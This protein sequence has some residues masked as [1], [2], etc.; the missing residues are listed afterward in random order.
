[1][2]IRA[3]EEHRTARSLVPFGLSG[4]SLTELIGVLALIAIVVALMLP[5]LRNPIQRAQMSKGATDEAKIADAAMACDTI[6]AALSDHSARYGSLAVDGTATPP[7]PLRLAPAFAHY[8]GLL[9]REQ[10]IDKPFA[11][12]IGDGSS[13]TQVQAVS[14]AG[15]GF[16]VGARV[17]ATAQTGFALAGGAVN[18]TVGSVLVEAIISGASAAEAKGLN[19]RID[20]PALGA[21]PDGADLNGRVKYAVPA[22]GMTTIYVYLTHR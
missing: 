17:D 3:P 9:L 12:R 6:S 15:S 20:G 5:R 22:N 13:G 7:R 10:L 18:S 2:D 4:F 16:A 14:L 11:V 8:D 21:G 1:M 19:D